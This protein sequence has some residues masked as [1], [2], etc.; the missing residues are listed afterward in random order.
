MHTPVEFLCGSLYCLQIRQIELE[1]DPLLPGF[2]LQLLDRLFGLSL[3][4]SRDIDFGIMYEECL[5]KGQSEDD[6]SVIRIE[7]WAP[8]MIYLNP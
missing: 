1:E 5:Y 3:T 4:P 7:M 8:R 6:G 2:L